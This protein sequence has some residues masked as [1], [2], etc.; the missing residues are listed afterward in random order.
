MRK[1]EKIQAA[2]K[3]TMALLAVGGLMA[4]DGE[5]Q[6]RIVV[7]IPDC[8]LALIQGGQVTRVYPIAV[9]ALATPSPS[10]EF[11]VAVRIQN[12]AWYTPHKVVPPGKANPLGTRWIGLSLHGYGIHGTNNPQSIGHRASHGCIRMRNRDVEELFTLVRVG[13]PVEFHAVRDSE[14]ANLFLNSRTTDR[15][16]S[17][18]L[19]TIENAAAPHALFKKSDK[20]MMAAAG[21][22]Q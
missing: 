9:G 22:G 1:P 15:S 13:D 10:G 21:G 12:P 5:V 17:V 18:F 16:G 11:S 8:K 7:N 6:R 4:E 14:L 3:V 19:S 20:P 2:V